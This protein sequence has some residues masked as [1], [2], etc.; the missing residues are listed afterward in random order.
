MKKENDPEIRGIKDS[1]EKLADRRRVG[2][3]GGGVGVQSRISK[4]YV[5]FT[6][7]DTESFV[8]PIVK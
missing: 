2:R 4:K 6:S 1:R 8:T 7:V 5:H 3:V